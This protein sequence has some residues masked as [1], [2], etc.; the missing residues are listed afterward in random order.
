[1]PPDGKVV[2]VKAT[3]KLT[4][5]GTTKTVT[6]DLQTK[7]SGN[8]IQVVGSI[9]IVFADYD[10]PNPSFGPITTEDHGELEFSIVLKQS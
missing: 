4:M 2:N 7:R 10:I 9:P 5:H 1:M 6:V 3:G 8:T